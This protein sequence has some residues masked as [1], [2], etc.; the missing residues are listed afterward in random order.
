MAL[1]KDNQDW[2]HRWKRQFGGGGESKFRSHEEPAMPRGGPQP[3]EVPGL[4]LFFGK[5]LSL[6]EIGYPL[7]LGRIYS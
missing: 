4:S 6:W 1:T 3:W 5:D 2:R 7:L